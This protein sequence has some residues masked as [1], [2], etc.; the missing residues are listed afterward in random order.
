MSI[1]INKTKPTLAK[2]KTAAKKGVDSEVVDAVDRIA[3][4]DKEIASL[5]LDLMAKERAKL[6]KALRDKTEDYPSADIV[7]F[8]GTKHQF[9]FTARGTVRTL[10]DKQG[11]RKSLGDKVYFEIAN[12]N[13]GDIDKY[14]TA[15]ESS[16]FVTEAQNGSRIG[17]LKEIK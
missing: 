6:V 14:L 11:V 10:V 5:G 15:A 8:T 4:I 1:T 16:P 17:K 12:I 13:L 3:I 9:E 2:A 7:T